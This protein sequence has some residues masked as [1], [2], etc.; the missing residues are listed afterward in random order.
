MMMCE[1]SWAA[2]LPKRLSYKSVGEPMY[3]DNGCVMVLACG[4][5]DAVTKYSNDIYTFL[6]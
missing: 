6:N 5:H 1:E 4:L 2:N 3:S